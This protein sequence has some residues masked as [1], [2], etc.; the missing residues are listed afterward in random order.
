MS[1]YFAATAEH[2][3]RFLHVR[4]TCFLFARKSTRTSAVSIRWSSSRYHHH[5]Y[6]EKFSD[7]RGE[8]TAIAV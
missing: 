1:N 4:D 8:F 6:L 3:R 5:R 7:Y 2:L